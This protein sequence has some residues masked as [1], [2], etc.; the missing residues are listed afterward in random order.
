MSRTWYFSASIAVKSA[1][2][3][4]VGADS[5]KSS[6]VI[7]AVMLPSGVCLVKTQ[8]SASSGWYPCFVRCWDRPV[9]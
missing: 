9:K 6:V 5:R 2:S 3:S 4:G 8:G 1:M 7:P